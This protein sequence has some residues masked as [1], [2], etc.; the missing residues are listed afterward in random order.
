ME[1]GD[2]LFF[3]DSDTWKENQQPYVLI[4]LSHITVKPVSYNL[5]LMYFLFSM[6]ERDHFLFFTG[7]DCFQTKCHQKKY[8]FTSVCL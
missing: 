3:K 8:K 7:N 2:E 6:V 4:D 5:Y 1:V